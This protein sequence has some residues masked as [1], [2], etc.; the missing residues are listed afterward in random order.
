M[1]QKKEKKK[2]VNTFHF[3][4]L[5]HKAVT[6]FTNLISHINMVY[7]IAKHES[8]DYNTVLRQS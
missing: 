2:K 6:K 8:F 3:L 7:E 1:P 5:T 4:R